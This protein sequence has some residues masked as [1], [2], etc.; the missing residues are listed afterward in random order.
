MSRSFTSRGF[1]LF[2]PGALVSSVVLLS[3]VRILFSTVFLFALW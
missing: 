1:L 3:L 2:F